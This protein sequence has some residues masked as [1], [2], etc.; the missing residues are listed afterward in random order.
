VGTAYG[1]LT[2]RKRQAAF[3][4]RDGE[5]PH[6][7]M[8]SDNTSQVEPDD[9]KSYAFLWFEQLLVKI[10]TLLDGVRDARDR[11]AQTDQSTV[12]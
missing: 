1:K 6:S 2:P 4:I 9:L 5:L 10:R 7:L 11:L 3:A 8:Q 12:T